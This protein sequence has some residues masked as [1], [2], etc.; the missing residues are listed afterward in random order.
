MGLV[1]P[2]FESR[3]EIA[4]SSP[5]ASGRPGRAIPTARRSIPAP[6]AMMPPPNA[7]AASRA[8]EPYALRLD[9]AARVARAGALTWNETGAGPPGETGTS[10]PIP[11]P[12]AT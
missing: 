1:Y 5:S 12:G 4:R 3:A 9:M 10:P 6:Q 11:P 2:S 7:S 8:G